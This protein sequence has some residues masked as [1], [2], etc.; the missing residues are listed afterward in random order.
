M[1]YACSINM[2]TWFIAKRR[3]LVYQGVRKVN[4]NVNECVWRNSGGNNIRRRTYVRAPPEF[5][6]LAVRLCSPRRR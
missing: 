1:Y 5:V 3:Y 2:S 6:S 4:V